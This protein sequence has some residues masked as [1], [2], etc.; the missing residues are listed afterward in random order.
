MG[1]KPRRRH[2][3]QTVGAHAVA[4]W[5]AA[6]LRTEHC[7]WEAWRLLMRRTLVD[8][9]TE[10]NK[11]RIQATSKKG[12]TVKVLGQN[13]FSSACSEVFEKE[14]PCHHHQRRCAVCDTQSFTQSATD[15]ITLVILQPLCMHARTTSCLVCFRRPIGWERHWANL[16][17]TRN[18]LH[19]SRWLPQSLRSYPLKV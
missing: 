7:G 11:E 9:F 1:T 14:E 2:R 6:G 16:V 8:A 19:Q 10:T 4:R 17:G 3:R 13:S 18:T 5:R 15:L 12:K